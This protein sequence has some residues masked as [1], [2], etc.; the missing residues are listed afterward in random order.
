M[1][2]LKDKNLTGVAKIAI[3]NKEQLAAVRPMDGTLVLETL[4]YPTRSARR[5]SS[6]QHR[7]E[8]LDKELKMAEALID[9]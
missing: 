8:S 1:K 3:R 7:P 6:S 2:A 4:Y 9:C 5:R